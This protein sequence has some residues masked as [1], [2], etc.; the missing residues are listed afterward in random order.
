VALA[1]EGRIVYDGDA[2]GVM[3]EAPR[4][5]RKASIEEDAR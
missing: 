3:D 4:S 2:A 1:G 5:R